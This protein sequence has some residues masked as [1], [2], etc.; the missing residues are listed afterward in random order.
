MAPVT[1]IRANWLVL[2][3]ERIVQPVQLN[4]IA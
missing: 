3:G 4:V 2:Q 1:L